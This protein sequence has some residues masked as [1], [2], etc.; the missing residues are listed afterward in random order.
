MLNED[1]QMAG[2][3]P[4]SLSTRAAYLQLKTHD[5]IYGKCEGI[6]MAKDPVCGMFVEEQ[7]D[8]IKHT[9]DS[10]EYFF[11]STKYW[12]NFTIVNCCFYLRFQSIIRYVHGPCV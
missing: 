9:V 7:P 11:Y 12:M 2:V 8:A 6:A 3:M 4:Y 10:K 1:T 5:T